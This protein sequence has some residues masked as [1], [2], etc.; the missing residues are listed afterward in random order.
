[1]KK[2]LFQIFILLFTISCQKD[3][4]DQKHNIDGFVQKGPFIQGAEVRI[5][6]LSVDL[7]PNGKTYFT[8]TN[9]DFGSF[10][11]DNEITEGY[12]EFVTTGFYFN[13]VTGKLSNAPISLRGI[14][15]VNSSQKFNLN[16]LTTLIAK[17]IKHLIINENYSFGDSKI[18]AQKEVLKVFYIDFSDDTILSFE[19]M[20]ISGNEISNSILL[21]VSCILQYDNSEAELSELIQKISS[22]IETD[23]VLDSESILNEIKSNSMLLDIN[24]IITNLESR[25]NHLGIQI[26]IPSFKNYIDKN[27]DGI[28]GIHEVADPEYIF[29]GTHEDHQNTGPYI[30]D[31][32]LTIKSNTEN[33]KIYYTLDGQDPTI[34]SNLYTSPIIIKGDP[35]GNMTKTTIKSFAIAENLE[36]SNIIEQTFEILYP[37][38]RAPSFNYLSG[39]HNNSLSIELTS[40]FPIYYTLDGSTPNTESKLYTTPIPINCLDCISVI[41]AMA[42]SP[43]Q[44]QSIVSTSIFKIDESFNP[45]DPDIILSNLEEAKTKLLGTWI[46]YVENPFIN[47]SYGVKI[48]FNSDNTYNT[49]VLGNNEREY[50]TVSYASVFHYDDIFEND[51][52][53]SR[54]YEINTLFDTNSKVNGEIKVGP[55][56]INIL[57]IRLSFN[58]NFKGLNL[59][60]KFKN[61]SNLIYHLSKLE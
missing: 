5:Q 3:E 59:I 13:E 55:N 9:N 54:F 29:D 23:G 8:E 40:P 30:D 22:D 19:E 50:L 34:N 11:L 53:W 24:S 45:N 49:Q 42:K 28:I 38:V 33:A 60:A 43:G 52:S 48:V 46:G 41:K 15:Y 37:D 58:N 47:K 18:K 20:D 26:T 32:E 14:G 6:E 51:P 16:I 2:T 17:R 39:T 7:I 4:L 44:R 61:A 25:Y 27:G 56:D 21:A 36:A 57:D 10:S 1:M 12:T 31:I 35:D